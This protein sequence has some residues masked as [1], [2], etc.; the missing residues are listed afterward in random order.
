MSVHICN[1][2]S[3]NL[4]GPRFF[5]HIGRYAAK[6]SDATTWR[7]QGASELDYCYFGILGGAQGCHSVGYSLLSVFLGM[8]RRTRQLT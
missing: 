2:P 8:Q 7:N 5:S 3:I 6:S 4:A 1:Q